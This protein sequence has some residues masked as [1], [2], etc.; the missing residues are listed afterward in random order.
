MVKMEPLGGV[1]VGGGQAGRDCVEKVSQSFFGFFS[2]RR[3]FIYCSE[4][5]FQSRAISCS[6]RTGE[7]KHHTQS[8]CQ[9]YMV[10]NA[11]VFTI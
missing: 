4:R 2:R 3:E 11:D 9:S 5:W 10:S 8:A 1:E 6:T 7:A